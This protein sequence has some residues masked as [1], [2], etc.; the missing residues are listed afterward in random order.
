MPQ[1]Q[2]NLP[3]TEVLTEEHRAREIMNIQRDI[4]KRRRRKLLQL[5]TRLAF[6]VLLPTFIAGYYYYVIATPMYATKSEFVIQ[7]AQPTMGGNQGL[8]SMFSGTSLATSQDSIAVQGYLQSMDAMLRLDSEAGFRA[9]FSQPEIDPLQRIEADATRDDTYGVFKKN[10]KISYDPTEGIIKM[11]VAAADPAVSQAFSERLI[12]Y[13][14]EQV[15]NL[16][17]RLREDQMKGARESFEESEAK[18]LAAQARVLEL[19]EQLGVLDPM[20]ESQALMAQIT[21]FETQ[22]QEK[23]LTLQ[24]LLDNQRPNRA[25]VEGAQGDVRR[26]ETL[27]AE[28]RSQ[29]TESGTTSASLARISGQLRLAET[30]LQT[31]QL[32]MTQALQQMET[33]RIEANRQTRYL[34]MAVNPIAPEEPTYPRAFENTILA[35]LIFGGIYLMFSLTASILREQVSG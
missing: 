22:L 28:L 10:V 18:M 33:A 4:V 7:Q 34:S 20:S 9:H 12:G 24:Q 2:K 1:P 31:R 26:L 3:S 27:I 11:E 13:A 16:T 35:F 25:R 32:L 23:R 6:F 8:A 21:T 19:Q 30:D 5:A 29:L 14:E 17:Q 15:D